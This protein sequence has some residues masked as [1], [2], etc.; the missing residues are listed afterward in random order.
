[1]KRLT[2]C[3]A[4]ALLSWGC[5]DS[6]PAEVPEGALQ[7]RFEELPYD[8][9]LDYIT[10]MAFLPGGSGE[11]LAIDLYGKVEHGRM[12]SDGAEPLMAGEL[13]DVYVDFDAGQLGL[14]VDPDF[15]DNQ[16]FYVATNR[17]KTNVQVRRYT[18]VPGDF[19]ATQASEVLIL[20]LQSPGSPRWHNISSL[21]FDEEGVMW[22]LVGDKGLFEPAQ[23][24]S[25]LL[26]SLIRI[27]PSKEEGEGGYL[28]PEGISM[29]SPEG[30]PVVYSIGIR[31]PWKG[32][33]YDGR[34]FFG[35]VGLDDREEINVIDGEGQNFGW[36][37]VEGLCAEDVLGTSP[38]CTLYRDPLV[39]YSRSNSEPFVR[40]DRDA[41]ATNKRSV[42]VGWI[43]E[44]MSDDPY[45]GR[46]DDV[47]VWGDF[48]V[49]FVRAALVD[50][51]G[52]SWHAGH[53]QFPTAW[54][55]GPDGYVY[56]TAYPATPPENPE[57]I[58][59]S[60]LY[61]VVLAD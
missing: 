2:I 50:D 30:D 10:D 27:V 47:V 14:A 24:P 18:L 52:N 15:A 56:V 42:Y 25:S 44:P 58:T 60:P 4:L 29:Y 39:S 36:P 31:S 54:G 16:Y 38:D 3:C 45:E 17:S 26:G 28:P 11:F 49:G 1:M 7:L 6:T 43:Y 37:V 35:D 46:W 8:T 12:E 32:R 22:L 53:L 51:L 20:D 19:E 40:D 55:R 34:W 33:Y 59:P 13:D 41:A 61:R 21:G 57:T 48:Y 23:D 5:G 9:S